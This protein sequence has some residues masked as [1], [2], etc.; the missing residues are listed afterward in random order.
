MKKIVC[1]LLLCVTILCMIGTG[2]A[3]IEYDPIVKIGLYYG[4]DSI[5]AAKLL[6][7]AGMET[8]YYIGTF[9]QTTREFFSFFSTDER[10]LT[11]L[12][13]KP[14][15]VTDS[16][17]YYD[18]QP[19]SYRYSIGCFH[20]EIK[21]DIIDLAGA[22]S[23][24]EDITATTD[25]RAF[26][27]YI[28]GRY[29]V[30]VGEFL[31]ADKADAALGG[32]EAATGYSLKRVGQSST[33][34]TVT[35]T[36][37]DK[38]IFEFDSSSM[39]LGIYPKSRD[40]WFKG[41]SYRGGF[42]YRRPSGN[43]L[44]VIN[45]VRMNDYIKG[46]IPYEVSADWPIEAQKAQ[47]ICAK[48]YTVNT[49]NKHKSLGFDL[50]N[51]TDCQVYYGTKNATAVSDSAVDGTFGIYATYNGKIAQTYYHS[52]SG[53][54]TEDAQYIWGSDVPYLK[55]VED[56]YLVKSL[57]FSFTV[58]LNDISEIL[59]AKGYTTQRITDYYVSR[60]SPSGNAIEVTFTQANGTPLKLSGDKARTAINSTAKN[61]RVNSHRYTVSGS[62]RVFIN[63]QASSAS[64]QSSYAVGA[65][66]KSQQIGLGS[67]DLRAITKNGV[68]TVTIQ[69]TGST[70]TV[71]GT[72]SGHNIGMSQWGA[73][74]MAAMGFTYDEI[75]RFYFT[76]V[77][78]EYVNQ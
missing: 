61:I 30:R 7:Y 64:L 18:V 74:A 77:S 67:S 49:M 16:E 10:A 41:Y 19:T 68:E 1:S 33:C 53:G 35:V 39:P 22:L 37:T 62:T 47:A 32:A 24:A 14:V 73:H 25:Y 46:V 69:N 52:S 6:N 12:K 42:E 71:A 63:G 23:I 78:V 54:Y 28:D 27:A 75:I 59:Q 66:G 57:P 21:E 72:G 40:T 48:C 76:G 31:T 3:A 45:V 4:T 44:T 11:V 9:D 38:I 55:A 70:Y 20:L 56:K 51:T 15:W 17:D 58:T 43:D 2:A 29:R 34:Y 60:Y 13:D 36:G 65:D 5:P 8:G 50:C 26:P